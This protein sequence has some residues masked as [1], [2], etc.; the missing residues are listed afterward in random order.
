[1]AEEMD[2]SNKKE[3]IAKYSFPGLKIA[4]II[5]G[6]SFFKDIQESTRDFIKEMD[7]IKQKSY[8]TSQTKV[9]G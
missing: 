8:A 3:L 1:M 9:F 2:Y 5:D 6:K 4:D 7:K